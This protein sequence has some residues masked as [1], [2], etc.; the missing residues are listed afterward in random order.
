M[1]LYQSDF[2]RVNSLTENTNWEFID[3]I[4]VN[5]SCEKFT[6]IIIDFMEQCIPSKEV[7]IRPNDRP[8]F[9]SVTRKCIRQR[10]RQKHIAAKSNR[11]TDWNKYNRPRNKV[12]NLKKAAKQHYFSNLGKKHMQK[13]KT[14]NNIGNIFEI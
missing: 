4:G 7:T 9:D 13:Q 14:L 6:N 5:E 2:I 10:D 11:L 1:E 12:N 8:W 3:H